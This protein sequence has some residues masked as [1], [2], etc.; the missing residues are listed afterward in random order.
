VAVVVTVVVGTGLVVVGRGAGLVV[1]DCAGVVVVVAG[2]VGAVGAVGAVVV[3]VAGPVVPFDDAFRASATA[4]ADNEAGR[5]SVTESVTSPT[6]A[7]ASAMAAVVTASHPTRSPAVR[8][9][10]PEIMTRRGLWRHQ[11]PAK[12]RL[13]AAAGWLA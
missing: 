4:A 12:L 13:R 1:V 10:M 2:P 5:F 9:R 8:R 11:A 6:A 3:V 7:R